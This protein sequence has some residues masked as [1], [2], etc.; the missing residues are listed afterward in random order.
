MFGATGKKSIFAVIMTFAG[1]APYIFG[2]YLVFYQ[3]FW[4]LKE[5]STGFSVWLVVKAIASLFIGH[6]VV[7]QT[8][9][10]TELDGRFAELLK[11]NPLL[12]G[13]AGEPKANG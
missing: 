3:G 13:A 2:C 7:A 1:F 11:E 5:L 8:Y 4:G 9:E 10:I 6:R 12:L